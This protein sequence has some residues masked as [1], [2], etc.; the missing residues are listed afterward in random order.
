MNRFV[1]CEWMP[2]PSATLGGRIAEAAA[3]VRSVASESAYA[4]AGWFLTA[5]S[6]KAALAKPVD[7][8]RL[9]SLEK[10][11]R[12]VPLIEGEAYYSLS[13][14]DGKSDVE[15][16][17]VSVDVHE[18]PIEP[19]QLVISGPTTDAFRA[20]VSWRE[21]LALAEL[22]ALR[23]G[24]RTV[25]GSYALHLYAE[26]KGIPDAAYAAYWGVDRSGRNPFYGRLRAV[27]HEPPWSIVAS[28]TWEEVLDPS[29]ASLASLTES[30]RL[31]AEPPGIP[32]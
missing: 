15:S 3:V 9:S 31:L 32:P 6:R 30:A 2:A 18:P 20:R 28:A 8:E 24:G 29:L 26:P 21:V 17:D 25:V 14:W 11:W 7:L 5:R 19:D 1:R 13:M 10:P 22:L 16:A 4:S 27:G 23:L 12:R